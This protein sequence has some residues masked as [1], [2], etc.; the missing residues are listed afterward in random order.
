MNPQ[1]L[2]AAAVAALLYTGAGLAGGT[3]PSI[4]RGRYLAVVA[5]CNDCH[6][7]G[8]AL[9][10]GETPE[11]EWLTGDL[12][13][14]SGPWGTTY[15]ANLRQYFA[16][17]TE[18]QWLAQAHA[19]SARPPMPNISL[20]TMT[21]EDLLALYRFTRSLGDSPRMIPAYLA[22]SEAPPPPFVKFP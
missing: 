13:G 21:D 8:Y 17:L 6:T 15:P 5:G 14:Y 22:P 18:Q 9:S 3:D 19:M 2:T 11:S 7:P 16:R 12:L 20:R 4:E 1:C 10:G